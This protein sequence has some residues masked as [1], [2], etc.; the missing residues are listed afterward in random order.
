MSRLVLTSDFLASLRGNLLKHEEETCAILYGRPVEISGRLARIVVH[1]STYPQAEAYNAR[2]SIRAQLKPEF[3]SEAVQRARRNGESVIFV[4]S[5][6]FPFNQFSETDDAGERELV[7]FL[8][9]RIPDVPHAAMLLT[10]ETSIAREIGTKKP[11][12]VVGVGENI[13]WG[14]AA[15]G[16][17]PA[18][19]YDRQIRAFGTA[20]Q[21]VLR[22]ICVAIVGLGGTGSVVLQELMYLGVRD[23]ILLDP[24]TVEE[25]NL[26]RL[27]GT[28][29]SDIGKAKVDVAEKWA[30]RIN[31]TLRIGAR[32][33]SALKA[34]VARSLAEA[35]FLFCC[36]DSHGSRAVLNQFAYQYLV[37]A[38]DMGVVIATAKGRVTHVA[39]RTQMLA[40]GLACMA[41]GNLLDAE[42]VR[43][44]LMTDF[45]RQQD[46][47]IVGQPEPAPAVISLN[48]TVASLAVTMF[49][50]ATVGI[51]GS[52]RFLNY[53]GMTGTC[54]P[55]LS[56]PHPSC[57]VCSPRGAI[58]R[59][60]EWP[61]PARQ[62]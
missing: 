45:E 7:P 40:P 2:T 20:G 56:I 57:I 33:E 8:S 27:V 13:I 32:K 19:R 4:H 50:N 25:T 60:D 36:T 18:E 26:N 55:V 31:R 17:K 54:R 59:G 9:G 62:D 38:I 28:V 6:P 12:R 24:D 10:P 1:E 35:D 51:P 48:S 29:P 11:L 46:P 47:Y 41:C 15:G 53:N 37:P 16:E 52:A 49:L 21:D 34:D 14:E 42:R 58:A 61:L 5:H 44:D 23:F 43:R 30:K 3:V 22:S 39:G